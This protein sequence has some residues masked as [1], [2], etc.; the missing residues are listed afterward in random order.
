M[1]L[2]KIKKLVND[3]AVTDNSNRTTGEKYDLETAKRIGEQCGVDFNFVQISEWYLILNF[4]YSD[5]QR[6]GRKFYLPESFF[7]S[8]AVEWFYDIDGD[9]DKTTRLFNA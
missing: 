3:F 1:N 2:K 8:L 9:P 7:W 6:T 5:F 4:F